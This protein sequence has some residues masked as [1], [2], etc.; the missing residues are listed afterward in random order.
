MWF[1]SASNLVKSRSS[2]ISARPANVPRCPRSFRPRLE[3]L[4]DRT[5]LSGGLSFADPIDY[6][7]GASPQSVTTG[8]FRGIGIQD[9]AVANFGSNN[10]S[11]FLGDG[12]GAF[13]LAETVQAG[14]RPYFVTT[15]HFH[16]PNSLDLAVAN[17]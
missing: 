10:V 6:A 7:V 4:E 13:R 3:I 5:L 8:D 2:R 14:T 9:L 12:H 15:G 17:S 1:Q 11:I 16:D